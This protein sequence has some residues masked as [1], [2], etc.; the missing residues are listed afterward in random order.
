MQKMIAL[1]FLILFT[2]IQYGKLISYWKCKVTNTSDAL[3]VQCDCDKILTDSNG[4]DD[5][6]VL[7]KT[8]AK[9]KVDERFYFHKSLVESASCLITSKITTKIWASHSDGFTGY[10]FQP[11][12]FITIY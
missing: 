8:Q 1:I 5:A 6:T 3:A 7:A 2:A 4:D 11:P 10:V 9:D 12:R